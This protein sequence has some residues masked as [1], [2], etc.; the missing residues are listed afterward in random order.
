MK[1]LKLSIFACLILL[2]QTTSMA[3]TAFVDSSIYYQF[4]YSES[5]LFFSGTWFKEQIVFDS[6][7]TDGE[8]YMVTF[9]GVQGDTIYNPNGAFA[10]LN[11]SYKLREKEDKIYFT[12]YLRKSDFP[13]PDFNLELDS[14]WVEDLL[15]YDYTLQPGDTFHLE[16]PFLNGSYNLKVDSVGSELFRD[17]VYCDVYYFNYLEGNARSNLFWIKGLGS[18]LGLNYLPSSFINSYAELWS[19]CNNQTPIYVNPFIDHEPFSEFCDDTEFDSITA[20]KRVSVEKIEPSNILIYPNPARDYMVVENESVSNS[21]QLIFYNL[22]GKIVHQTLWE[23]GA[24]RQ[25]INTSQWSQGIYF[26]HFKDQGDFRVFKVI[27][28]K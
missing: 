6:I 3:Q 15:I 4:R 24:T 25:K 8:H 22:E 21:A 27:V 19:V 20:Y 11:S 12:G 2:S 13:Y 5:A 17:S 9:V 10:P 26:M 7:G 18:S 1:T 16:L 23:Q 28:S 14:S